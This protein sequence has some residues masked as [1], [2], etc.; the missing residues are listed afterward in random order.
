MEMSFFFLSLPRSAILSMQ[1]IKKALNTH[2]S[3]SEVALALATLRQARSTK[4]DAKLTVCIHQ[5]VESH[6]TITLTSR[7]FFSPHRAIRRLIL[8]G[9][10]LQCDLFCFFLCGACSQFK[11]FTQLMWPSD[12]WEWQ[13]WIYTLCFYMLP[14]FIFFFSPFWNMFSFRL[15]MDC[16][17]KKQTGGNNKDR[18]SCHVCCSFERCHSS[19]LERCVFPSVCVI[20]DFIPLWPGGGRVW[21]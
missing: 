7:F 6:V 15:F 21:F 11:D 1:Q 13:L 5:D 14:H 8:L 9:A 17:L 19:W 2:C 16:L 3:Y 12:A 20:Q 4:G 18:A 10:S